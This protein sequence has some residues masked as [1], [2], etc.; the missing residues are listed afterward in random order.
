MKIPGS[1]RGLL[2]LSLAAGVLAV[3]CSDDDPDPVVAPPAPPGAVLSLETTTSADTVRLRWL[4]AAGAV[5]YRAELVG[6]PS[7]VTSGL[8]AVFTRTDGLQDGTT[9]TATVV[10]IGEGGETPGAR[11]KVT[12]DFFPWDEN[13]A[14]SLHATAQGM[15]SF[16]N[17]SPHG[18]LE[19]YTGIGYDDLNC[20]TCHLPQFTGGC[21]S[22]HGTASPQL[23]ATVDAS[24]SG[25]CGTCH[26]RQKAE[27]ASYTD[28]HRSAGMGCMDC[29]TMGDVHGDGTAYA[30]ML[31]PGAIDP[32]CE[33]CHQQ[34]DNN[35]FHSS[36]ADDLDCAV[37][38]TQ[39]VVTCYNCHFET[40]V[41]GKKKIAYGQFKDWNFLINRDGK[42]HLGNFQSVK[43]EDKTVV[44][45]APFYAHTISRNAVR[46][47]GDCHDNPAVAKWFRDGAIDVVTWN[48][49]TQKLSHR[50]GFI[51]VP[52]N[53]DAG[54]L[55][56]D[57]VDLD[58]VGGSVWS[59]LETGPDRSHMPY[60][61]PLTKAQM[62][63]IR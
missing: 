31:E 57:F 20:K 28:V 45:W 11:V 34:I 10:A 21:K 63:K 23:G 8:E 4:G 36:H 47:C 50:K 25:V 24:L 29:H 27:A 42:V 9:Y 19:V 41:F 46:G 61:T 62:D 15:Q 7:T 18:G 59:F 52:P 35:F 3:A 56:F 48:E 55:L 39:S 6:G 13:F 37:C 32:E 5:S 1:R 53:Y 38:H 49:G 43:W 30:S 54:G 40:E 51:P 12:T 2:A 16:Y 33:D 14:T 60:G 26:S 58:Q 17:A 22:C 44:G